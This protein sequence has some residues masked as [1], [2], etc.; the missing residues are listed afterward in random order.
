MNRH[1][2]SSALWKCPEV[3]LD[4]DATEIV[5]NK[6]SADYTC[7]GNKVY[8]P[9]VGHVAQTGQVVATDFR[10]GNCSPAKDNLA[11]I[12]QCQEALPAGVQVRHLRIDSAGYQHAILDYCHEQGIQLQLIALALKQIKTIPPPLVPI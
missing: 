12:K 1:L 7:K 6:T 3:T 9:M 8:M 4:I 10:A 5:A 2:L 11:F